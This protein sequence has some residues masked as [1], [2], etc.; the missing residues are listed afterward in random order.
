[1]PCGV[2][3]VTSDSRNSGSEASNDELGRC[4]CTSGSWLSAVSRS[5]IRIFPKNASSAASILSGE[6]DCAAEFFFENLRRNWLVPARNVSTN[7]DMI[8]YFLVL[9]GV[10]GYELVSDCICLY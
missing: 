1:V 2:V 6:T 8:K 9:N 10:I 4:V 7:P 5:S 3:G